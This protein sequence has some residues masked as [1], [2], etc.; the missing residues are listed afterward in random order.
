MAASAAG[1]AHIVYV[2][3]A[4][5]APIMREYIAVRAIGEELI[6]KTG[7]PA[8]ML[9]PWYVLGPGHR[10]PHLLAPAYWLCERIPSTRAASL[11]LGLVT[12]SQ[13]VRALVA[14]VEHPPAGVRI[15]GVQEIR[16]FADMG[17]SRSR[18]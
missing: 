14:A 16:S 1:I 4:Q 17:E 12:L 6:R 5:P 9:R 10:W 18:G 7:I 8:T 2:S 3:I 11:R 13:M 15:V